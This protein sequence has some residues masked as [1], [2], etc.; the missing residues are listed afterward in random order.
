MKKLVASL[1]PRVVA[2]TLAVSVGEGCSFIAISSPPVNHRELPTFD[3][4]G[5]LVPPVADAAL[6]V[7]GVLLT[8][9]VYGLCDTAENGHTVSCRERVALTM[10]PLTAVLPLGSALYG[11]VVGARCREAKDELMSRALRTSPKPAGEAAP[12]RSPYDPADPAASPSPP[13]ASP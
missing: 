2:A 9:T 11:Y 6:A 12:L 13:P 1:G 4:G 3:C 8:A 5:S 7:G 10:I